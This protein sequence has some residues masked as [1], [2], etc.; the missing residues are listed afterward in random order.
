MS[1]LSKPIVVLMTKIL[2]PIVR[3]DC[4]TKLNFST[5][6]VFRKIVDKVLLNS[7]AVILN[8]F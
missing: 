8:T 5:P 3:I 2:I 1:S 7:L 6:S 4:E